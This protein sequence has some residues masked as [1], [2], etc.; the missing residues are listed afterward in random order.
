MMTIN[1]HLFHN[2]HTGFLAEPQETK[3]RQQKWNL[4]GFLCV[5]LSCGMLL[6]KKIN[7]EK[8]KKRAWMLVL[9]F[10]VYDCLVVC[11]CIRK[12]IVKRGRKGRKR[13]WMYCWLKCVCM[14]CGMLL[15]ERT[16]SRATTTHRTDRSWLKA[17][18]SWLLF[19]VEEEE[20]APPP[21]PVEEEE[22]IPL[23]NW[24]WGLSAYLHF[25]NEKE[26]VGQIFPCRIIE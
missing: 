10:F 17:M 13:A 18:A 19:G 7:C 15:Y 14:S 1:Y 2:T 25:V 9:D 8:V 23:K 26:K 3:Q 5:R 24:S 22:E 6:Y 21:P 4:T 11:C 16:E 12:S 20:E